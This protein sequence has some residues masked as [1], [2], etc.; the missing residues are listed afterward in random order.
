MAVEVVVR[1]TEAIAIAPAASVEAITRPDLHRCSPVMVDMAAAPI[2]TGVAVTAPATGV[3]VRPVTAP[4]LSRRRGRSN[5]TCDT[6]AKYRHCCVPF[7]VPHVGISCGNRSA[8]VRVEWLVNV[9][10]RV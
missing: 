5:R 6:H 3:A 4:G 10:K 1:S 7:N 2:T 9:Q 8:V